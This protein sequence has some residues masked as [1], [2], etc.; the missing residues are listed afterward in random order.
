[1]CAYEPKRP[2]L[3]VAPNPILT[4]Q[5]RGQ[6]LQVWMNLQRIRQKDFLEK[7]DMRRS[8]FA[9]YI[10]GETD[11]AAVEQPTA[12]RLLRAMGIS[13]TDAWELLGIPE[14]RRATFRSFRPY[15]LGHGT[16]RQHERI[17]LIM[18]RLTQPLFGSLALPAGVT[19]FLE[20]G[21]NN[22]PHQ[23]YRLADGRLYAVGDGGVIT[24]PG[25]V[26]LGGLATADFSG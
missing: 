26:H 25:A 22:L 11:L 15:P 20:S 19:L 23:I 7:A 3:M 24:T 5:D 14:D 10:S 1:M 21:T 16:D 9:R 13:D 4:P 18:E 8:T 6:A 2:K 17:G 12:D